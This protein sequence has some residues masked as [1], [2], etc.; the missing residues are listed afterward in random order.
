MMMRDLFFGFLIALSVSGLA[1]ASEMKTVSMLDGKVELSI[2]A[3]FL[4]MSDDMKKIKYSGANPPRD[5][6]TDERGTVNIGANIAAYP[7]GKS[8]AEMLSLLSTSMERVRNISSWDHKELRVIGGREYG[9]LEC[10]V[11]TLDTEVYNFIYFTRSGD[12]LIVITT[13]STVEKL[14]EWKAALMESVE[15]TKIVE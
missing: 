9:V 10:T 12:K 3:V 15:S 1:T 4:P 8:M 11:K 6:Y 5:I 13:N 7:K 14:S 2:P